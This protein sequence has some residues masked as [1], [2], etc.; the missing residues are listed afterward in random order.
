MSLLV[1]PATVE[2]LKNLASINQTLLFP[3]GNVL[4]T[5]SVKKH[6]YCTVEVPEKF[7]R[8]FSIYDM[9]Q[10]LSA[11][12]QFDKPVLDF[13]EDET[14]VKLS[15]ESGGLA[16]KYHYGDETLAYTPD[17]KRKIELPSTDVEFKLT[18]VQFKQITN[19][20]RVLG[21]P[22]LAL[23][24]D[25][26]TLSL[27][28]LDSENT[29]TN[30]TSLAIGEAPSDTTFSLV[31][32][33]EYMKMIAGTYDVSVSKEGLSRFKHESMPLIYHILLE[34]NSSRYDG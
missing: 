2:I 28:T 8:R 16:V 13:E 14:Y 19:M 22:Q 30:T 33:I 31:W 29:S 23:V 34:A 10:F 20:S 7:P 1:T 4:V 24:S 5:R 3:K 25:G 27:E 26:S 11:V 6:T 32:R 18:E 17:P 12:T 9:N 21:T 15:D